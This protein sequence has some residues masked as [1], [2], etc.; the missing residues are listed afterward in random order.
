M[1]TKTHTMTQVTHY[2]MMTLASACYTFI[3]VLAMVVLDNIL[4]LAPT[5][6]CFG[7]FLYFKNQHDKAQSRI[8]EA[9]Y[10]TKNQ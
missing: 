3:G 8:K 6:I 10:L 4:V 2:T 5:F 1:K 9:E 7:S